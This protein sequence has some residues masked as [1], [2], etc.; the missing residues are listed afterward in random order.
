MKIPPL[1]ELDKARMQRD[2]Y[3]NLLKM[4]SPEKQRAV[5]IGD[6]PGPVSDISR[7]R[8]E[9]DE[10]RAEVKRLSARLRL[11]EQNIHPGSPDFRDKIR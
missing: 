6:A 7:L 8:R 9:N 10:L 3:A 4:A 2:Y 1:T 5:L 11:S